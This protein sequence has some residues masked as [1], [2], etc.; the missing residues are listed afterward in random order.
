M[1]PF[2]SQKIKEDLSIIIDIQSG[3]VRGALVS[4]K[5]NY[6]HK[7]VLVATHPIH[8]RAHT[9]SAHLTKMMLKALHVVVSTLTH[10]H[11][12]DSISVI[13]SSPWV[14]SNSK[15]INMAF[16]KDTQVTQALITDIIE[17]GSDKNSFD[18]DVIFVEKKIFEIKINGYPVT[19]YVDRTARSIDISF[20][21]SM[22]SV[23]L[24][25]KIDEVFK[26]SF[27][28]NKI[29]H[30]SSLLLNFV[31][32]RKELA[33][34]SDYVYIH[35]HDELTDIFVVRKGQCIHMSS[36]PMG[37]STLVRKVSEVL[38]QEMPVADSTLTLYQGGKL[39]EIE[40][41]KVAT[42]VEEFVGQWLSQY[43]GSLEKS[44]NTDSIPRVIYLFAHSHIDVF[45]QALKSV[46]P[47]DI[48]FVNF[49]LDTMNMYALA[50]DDV[51][52][53]KHQ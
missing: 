50:L 1:F 47:A 9:D 19:K 41:Q 26:K 35:I 51:L 14:I 20:A 42:K 12:V 33:E 27:G 7:I 2:A 43:S 4:F 48:H 30:Y 22:S 15:T 25:G 13:L 34:M 36:F 16:E 24:L 32:L 17:K 44:L 53:Y 21:T 11:R 28:I 29:T 5:K 3:L 39:D 45:K 8:R 10:H 31:A 6:P 46:V 49:D 38:K 18:E 23:Q 37:I 52:Y 40:K